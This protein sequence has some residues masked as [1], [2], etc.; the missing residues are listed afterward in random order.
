M[1]VNASVLLVSKG[2]FTENSINDAISYK[3]IGLI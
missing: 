1:S 3:S 2:L